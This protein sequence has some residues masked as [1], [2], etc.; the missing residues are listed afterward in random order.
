MLIA[1]L[2]GLAAVIVPSFG[3]V[4]LAPAQGAVID[5]SVADGGF[6]VRASWRTIATAAALRLLPGLTPAREGV[7]VGPSE[8]SGDYL[9]QISYEQDGAEPFMTSRSRVVSFRREGSSLH[10]V[11]R[12]GN[13]RPQRV[14]ARIPIRHEL[15]GALALDF[16]AGFSRVFLEEDRNGSDYWVEQDA[17][18][19]IPLSHREIRKADRSGSTLR[20]EQHAIDMNDHAMIVRYSLRPYRPNPGFRPFALSS[21]D[22]LGFFQTYPQQFGASTVL[23]A[24][25]FDIREPVVF[26]LS[27]NV[28]APYRQAVKDGALYWNGAFGRDVVRVI[29][30]AGG[31]GAPDADVNV[32]EWRTAP[33]RSSASHM[34]IDPLTGQ[35]T[36]A[37]VFIVPVAGMADADPRG[38]RLRY[39][40]A[41][42]VGHALGLRHN[43]ARGPLTTVMNYL[44][45]AQAEIVGRNVIAGH[46]PPLA[47]DA[48]AI[49]TV[50]LD[51]PLDVTAM[52]AFCT[53]YQERCGRRSA[54]AA[55]LVVLR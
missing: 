52:P 7:Q 11:E 34:Q 20:F 9:L 46:Q 21:L 53:D 49:R 48:A 6:G 30:L 14:L 18:S 51:H 15:D 5:V 23:Y 13:G 31:Q 50:Y 44:S 29:D 40:V 25:K 17:D 16:N 12:P 2:R 37:Y 47:Y 32:I 55:S 1:A 35:I 28:P 39:V 42:E 41:H 8:L 43:F 4:T 36:R 26:A 19:F 3:L 33:A 22:H 54:P 27:A 45:P 38:D 24:T 10:M